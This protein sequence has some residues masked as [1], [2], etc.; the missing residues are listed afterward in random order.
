M[1]L[2][3]SYLALLQYTQRSGMS[4]EIRK[5]VDKRKEI[6]EMT[7]TELQWL[8][9]IM[10]ALREADAERLYTV[11]KFIRNIFQ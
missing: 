3:V 4:S 1:K 10:E 8:N 9:E 7:E 11:L 6:G 2:K 5:F